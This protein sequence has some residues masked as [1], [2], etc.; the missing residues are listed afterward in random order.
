M[1]INPYVKFRY[2]LKKYQILY[3]LIIIILIIIITLYL[4]YLKENKII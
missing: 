3:V 1:N 2:N 4:C